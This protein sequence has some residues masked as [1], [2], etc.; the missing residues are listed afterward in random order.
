M[1]NSYLVESVSN[2][3]TVKGSHLE[4][5]LFDNF[6]YKY[7]IMVDSI[8]NYSLFFNRNILIKNLIKNILLVLVYGIGSYLVIINKIS[9]GEII[10]FQSFF[11]YFI[12]ASDRLVSLFDD[13]YNFLIALNRIEDLFIIR[14]ERFSNN[15]YYLNYKLDGNILFKN[16]VY[17]VGSRF[18]FDNINI[19]IKKGE[20]ILISGASGSGKSSFVKILM[21][22]IEVPYGM[23]S[24]D[25]I[26]I[27]HYHLEN[28]RSNITYVSSNEYLFTDTLKN[29]IC[30]YKEISEDE[31]F[32]VCNL[33]LVDE[34]IKNDEMK[35]NKMV[36]ENGFN[37]SNG[38]RQRIILA[39]SLIRNSSI[40]IFDESFGQ[41]D[42]SKEKKI[43]E[44]I[45]KYL[46]NKIIIV[47]SH[48]FNN[49]KMF[50]RV[51]KLENGKIY[52]S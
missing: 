34:I 8:Y 4:K 7:K 13:Y 46:D 51:L 26:D 10:V 5:R 11:N 32:N 18:L 47:I 31:F 29:N 16:L 2:V 38:E 14:E 35:Y 15:F 40:Y 37:F 27:N 33:C 49:K 45:F 24:V 3:D 36:E 42:I 17:K 41:I 48:R 21:R 19:E 30:L 43:L 50:D 39:R 44:N 6:F 22:Y 20:K 28:I 1:I 25:G 9:F 23:V 52:E 12:G